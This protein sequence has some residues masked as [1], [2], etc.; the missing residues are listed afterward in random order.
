MAASEQLNLPL[1]AYVAPKHAGS[2]GRT[3]S[4]LESSTPQI[5]VRALKKAE[6][7]DGYIVRCYELTGK[8]VENARITFPAQIL[9]A[10]ECNGIEEK[11]GAAETEGRSLIVSAGK[12]APKTYRVRLAAP[13]QKSAFEVKSAPVTL[14]YNTVAFTTDEFYTY[15][16]FDNQRGSFAAELIPAELTCNGVRL[17]L[18][19]I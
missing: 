12:F 6:D 2:L 1:V 10:E 15:Y 19:H 4:M 17:S 16:R 8:P 14:S 11:I 7:G 3:F 5:G 9:S 18:I 13:A